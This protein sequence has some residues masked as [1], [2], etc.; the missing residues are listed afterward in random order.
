MTKSEFISPLGKIL[1]LSH[2]GNLIYCNWDN[3]DCNKKY[4]KFLKN[5]SEE[6]LSI[7]DE[8][9]SSTIALA[10]MQLREYFDGSRRNFSLP[11]KMRG[12]LFQ[13]SVWTELRQ[14]P[15][16]ETRSYGEISRKIN[17]CKASRAVANACGANP[18]AIIIPCHRVIA[19]DAS[20]GGYTGGVAIKCALLNLEQD[21]K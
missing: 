9:D 5:I 12:T 13:Q 11:V 6:F 17:S 19:S 18:L 1:L 2:Q 14:I 16:G 20:V 21:K 4:K 8:C 7:E 10:L 3:D 15:Y